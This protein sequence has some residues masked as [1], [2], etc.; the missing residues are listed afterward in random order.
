MLQPMA[1]AKGLR[2]GRI[3]L[4]YAARNAMLPSVTSFGMALGT[5]SLFVFFMVAASR[6]ATTTFAYLPGTG[7]YRPV[8]C[9]EPFRVLRSRSFWDSTNAA[10]VMS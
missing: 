6:T 2:P 9:R 8:L 4:R 7:D 10:T 1:E 3:M 5:A